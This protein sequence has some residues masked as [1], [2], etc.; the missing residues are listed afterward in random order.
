MTIDYN[1]TD[2]DGNFLDTTFHELKGRK[3]ID[4]S[5]DADT[6]KILTD[7]G[8]K[9]FY[10]AAGECCSSSWFEN[11]EEFLPALKGSTI[12]E[13]KV[14]IL[15][16]QREDDHE[17]DGSYIQ[18]Y[19]WVLTSDKGYIDIEMRNSSNGYYGG[20]VEHEIVEEFK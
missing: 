4:C 13:V 7:D 12:K 14:K 1:Q 9:H 16:I 17:E 11:F 8:I 10:W 6:I 18:Y 20:S 15:D 19:C 2:D 5:G 3:I